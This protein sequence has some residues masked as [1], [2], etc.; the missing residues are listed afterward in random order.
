MSSRMLTA[1]VYCS[2]CGKGGVDMF[3]IDEKLL[4]SIANRE[5]QLESYLCESEIEV[6]Y[7]SL[8]CTTCEA[9]TQ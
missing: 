8:G 3:S 4:D 2:K 9:F 6:A 5:M 1:C 7:A